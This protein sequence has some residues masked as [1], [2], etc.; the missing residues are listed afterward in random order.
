M[1]PWHHQEEY[2]HWDT[3]D[4]DG[5]GDGGGDDDDVVKMAMVMVRGV[6]SHFWFVTPFQTLEVRGI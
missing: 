3:N 6:A 5:D 1:T 4:D 2:T